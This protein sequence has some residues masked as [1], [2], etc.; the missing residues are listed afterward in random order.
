MAAPNVAGVAAMIRSLFPKLS[1]PQVK[2]ILME[3]GLSTN[4]EVILGGDPQNTEVFSEIS[5][6]GNMVNMYNA[7]ILASKTK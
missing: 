3:S 1:A 7:I 2:Q 5:V 4:Q 6:S